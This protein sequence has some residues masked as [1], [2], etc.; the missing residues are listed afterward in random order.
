MKNET[1]SVVFKYLLAISIVAGFFWLLVSIGT[2]QVNDAMRDTFIMLV[3]LIAGKFGTIVDFE[4]GSSK[5][6]QDKNEMLGKKSPP[7]V[8]QEPQIPKLPQEPTP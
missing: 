4:W 8:P 5:S 1:L 7:Q 3:G 2:M 6:S